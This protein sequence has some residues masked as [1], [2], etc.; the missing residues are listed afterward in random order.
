MDNIRTMADGSPAIPF[1]SPTAL[2]L[3]QAPIEGIHLQPNWDMNGNTSDTLRRIDNLPTPA[4]NSII[5]SVT[6][7]KVY[8]EIFVY[9]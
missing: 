4:V 6:D 3:Q 5:P 1:E 8:S 9:I 2:P 7:N